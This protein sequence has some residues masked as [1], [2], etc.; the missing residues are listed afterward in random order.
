VSQVRTLLA[1]VLALLLVASGVE[2][3]ARRGGPP[4]GG[5]G[6]EPGYGA[7]GGYGRYPGGRPGYPGGYPPPPGYPAVPYG[8]GPGGLPGAPPR[9]GAGSLG[10][11]WREQQDEARQGVRQ[12]QMAPL[13]RVIDNLQRR[14]PGRELDAGI[15]M[16]GQRPVYRVRWVTAEGRRVDF[17][18]DAASGAVLSGR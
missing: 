9:P 16:W 1:A 3:Q 7:P 6:G 5:Y 12:G 11:D 10:A 15:E 8:R 2:A 14:A 17:I 4:R 13:G 18:V